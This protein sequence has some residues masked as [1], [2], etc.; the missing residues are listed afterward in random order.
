[1]DYYRADF[2]PDSAFFDAHHTNA[3]GNEI[4][5]R[6]VAQELLMPALQDWNR[7]VENPTPLPV[8]VEERELP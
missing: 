4:L 7:F 3:T 6:I 5:S 2:L 1:M 8:A